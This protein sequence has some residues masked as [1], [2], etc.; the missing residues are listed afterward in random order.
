[1]AQSPT[2]VVLVTGGFHTPGITQ[3]LKE[4]GI[5]YAVI[6][7]ETTGEL[8]EAAYRASFSNELPAIDALLNE[9]NQA[10]LLS[11]KH[12]SIVSLVKQIL[13]QQPPGT[14][15]P[16]Q[17]RRRRRLSRVAT[18]L[19]LTFASIATILH[20]SRGAATA[21]GLIEATAHQDAFH[22]TLDATPTPPQLIV[23]VP[24]TDD[25]PGG[26]AV[27]AAAGPASHLVS[28]ELPH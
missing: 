17:E 20:L 25:V 9:V 11:A 13:S 23:S 3:Q 22:L 19:I 1:M 27:I 16:E 18:Q 4:R 21:Q 14:A 24:D 8:N 7:P 6:A 28:A 12:G 15:K 5:A 10:A 26:R 2:A